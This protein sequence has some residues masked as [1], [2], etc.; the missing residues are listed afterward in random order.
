[1]GKQGGSIMLHVYLVFIVTGDERRTVVA[2]CETKERAEAI[3]RWWKTEKHVN[4]S[5][6]AL[7]P[8]DERI[9]AQ[10]L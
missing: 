1:M 9:G 5:Y 3:A 8:I 10:G 7:I 2:A 6:T 4:D